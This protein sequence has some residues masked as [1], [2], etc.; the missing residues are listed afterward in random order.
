[1]GE[2]PRLVQIHRGSTALGPYLMKLRTGDSDER[3]SSLLQ[4]PRSTLERLMAKARE[5][6]HQDFVPMNLGIGHITIEQITVRNLILPN[7][8]FGEVD[9]VRKP[10][11]IIDGTYNL[12]TKKLQLFVPKRDIFSSQISKPCEAIFA[13]LL[14]CL[15]NRCVRP[16]FSNNFRCSDND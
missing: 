15:Y 16:L 3:I 7:G 9:G 4:I 6:L 14:R 11:V 1:M 5:K 8:L 10:V 13:C 2:V 12:C